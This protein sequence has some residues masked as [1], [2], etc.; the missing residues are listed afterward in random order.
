MRQQKKYDDEFKREAV[1]LIKAGGKTISAIS[2]DLGVSK[3][4]L[5]GWTYKSVEMPDGAIIRNSEIT[6]LKRELADA[7]IE[8][9]I[10]K[11]AVAIFSLPSK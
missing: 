5:Y 8:R 4:T 6:R 9:D 3:S 11:K 2:R 1:R 7:R 10:L